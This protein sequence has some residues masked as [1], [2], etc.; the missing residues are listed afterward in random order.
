M[1]KNNMVRE[2]V[3]RLVE[4]YPKLAEN[5]NELLAHY[6]FI[7]DNASGVEGIGEATSAESILRELRRLVGSSLLPLPNRTVVLNERKNVK[8]EFNHEFNSLA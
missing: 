8:R 4:A 6:W 5:K 1:A 2:N 7:Y 3:R